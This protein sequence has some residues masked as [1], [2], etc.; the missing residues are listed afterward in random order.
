MLKEIK[1][2]IIGNITGRSE[3]SDD[4]KQ[5]SEIFDQKNIYFKLKR[6]YDE[7]SINC[8]DFTRDRYIDDNIYKIYFTDT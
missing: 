5:V 4:Y 6:E 8:N 2:T 7:I 1:L 3:N